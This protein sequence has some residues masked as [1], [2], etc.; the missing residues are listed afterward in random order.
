MPHELLNH[1]VP[2]HKAHQTQHETGLR[3][4]PKEQDLTPYIKYENGISVISLKNTDGAVHTYRLNFKKSGSAEIQVEDTTPSFSLW[5]STD[6]KS[7][8]LTQSASLNDHLA[9][10]LAS[11]TEL[12]KKNSP[13]VSAQQA[14]KILVSSYLTFGAKHN[15]S[16]LA[17]SKFFSLN[18]GVKLDTNEAT[19]SIISNGQREFLQRGQYNCL[20]S[21]MASLSALWAINPRDIECFKKNTASEIYHSLRG[22]GVRE[23]NTV[24]HTE[25][26]IIH[27]KKDI[28]TFHTWESRCCDTPDQTRD[29]VREAPVGSVVFMRDKD[30]NSKVTHVGFITEKGVVCHNIGASQYKDKI[31]N[32]NYNDARGVGISERWEICGVLIPNNSVLAVPQNMELLKKCYSN[33]TVIKESSADVRLDASLGEISSYLSKHSKF[34]KGK[35]PEHIAKAIFDLNPTLIDPSQDHHSSTMNLRIR[36]DHGAMPI[37]L[38]NQWLVG[39][40][41]SD[42]ITYESGLK[43]GTLTLGRSH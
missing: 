35:S 11:F 41:L 32:Y 36:T 8:T 6:N 43:S 19:S 21:T 25:T 23:S 31:D 20:G 27:N 16:S 24:A 38:M 40:S 9:P 1:K 29:M 39:I 34:F 12:L 17:C 42:K 3:V 22:T 2:H 4:P 33:V 30:R 10:A 14:E 5:N 13:W 37:R 7:A 26:Q 18:P 28:G 15:Q